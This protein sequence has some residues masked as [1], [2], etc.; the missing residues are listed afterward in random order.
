MRKTLEDRQEV[1]VKMEVVNIEHPDPGNV[2]TGN[3]TAPS[4]AAT[5][6]AHTLSVREGAL[7]RLTLP[8]GR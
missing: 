1:E 2:S 7:D 5:V 8:G 6:V 4:S 3:D